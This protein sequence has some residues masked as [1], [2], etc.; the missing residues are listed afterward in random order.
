[1]DGHMVCAYAYI[2]AYADVLDDTTGWVCVHVVYLCI[3]ITG[4]Y[5]FGITHT[6]QISVAYPCGCT[7]YRYC[8]N[9]HVKML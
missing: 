6:L 7:N 2:F 3:G 5:S 9:V 8:A 4:M 1:M